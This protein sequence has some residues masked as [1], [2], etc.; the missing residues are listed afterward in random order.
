MEAVAGT[1]AVAMVPARRA[2]LGRPVQAGAWSRRR[3]RAVAAVPGM[4]RQL[5]VATVQVPAMVQACTVR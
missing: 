1:E 5:A 4:G 3:R 2:Q